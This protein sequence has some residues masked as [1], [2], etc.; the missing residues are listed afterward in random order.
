LDLQGLAAHQ[1]ADGSIVFTDED[2]KAR[3]SLPK[4]WMED[5][6]VDP[7]SGDGAISIGVTLS[8]VTYHGVPAVRVHAD[9]AWLYDP[10]RV[11]PVRI[12]PS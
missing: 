10:A 5:S 8:L 3:A 6:A 2:G 1:Q 11:F 9:A 7:H 4:G 12:D